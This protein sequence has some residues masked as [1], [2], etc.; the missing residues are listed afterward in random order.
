MEKGLSN[1]VGE[2][3]TLVDL[4]RWRAD[5]SPNRIAYR[6][7]T[8]GATQEL[9]LTYRELDYQARSIGTVLQ[10]LEASGE[11]VLLLYP[12]GLEYIAA[13]FGCLY[14][15]AV[16]V[17]AYPPR[18]NRSLPRL[19]AVVE[20]A[21]A[22]L[23]LTTSH[24]LSKLDNGSDRNNPLGS[25]RCIATD[26]GTRG[27]ESEWKVPHLTSETLAFLQ[28]TSGSTGTP[29]GVMVTH[30][31]LLHNSGALAYAFEYSPES[32]CVSWLPVYHDMGL[33]GG[34]LQPLYGGFPCALMSP[35]SFLQSP[36]RWLEAITRFKGTISGAP[37]FAYE[38]CVS[39][40]GP[41]QRAHL[42]L[43]SWEV[44]FNG[45]E[46]IR[47]ETLDRFAE[48]F[49]PCGFRKEAFFACYGLAES[50]L[51]VSGGERRIGPSIK[52]VASRKLGKNSAIE[53]SSARDDVRRV[54][55]CGKNL[56]GQKIAILDPE[57]GAACPP[58]QIGEVWVSSP[59][60]AK[61]YWNRPDETA[62]TFKARIAETG[63]GPFLR[64]GDLGFFQDGELYITGR[65]KD[66]I[67]IRGLNHYPQD[68]EL[69]AQRSH[70]V[71]RRGLAA[72]FS[73]EEAG[74]ERLVIIQE[75][76]PRVRDAGTVID[77]I[78]RAVAEDHDL[79]VEA[80]GLVRPGAISKT[81]SGKIR[82]H[83][84][85]EAF[86]T[87]QLK[88]LALW[89]ASS[90]E[91]SKPL[92]SPSSLETEEQIQRWLMSLVSSKL[93]VPER[94]MDVNAPI[95]SYGMDS[96]QA[97]ELTHRIESTLGVSLPMSR[98]LEGPSIA[99]IASL[100]LRDGPA[101]ITQTR[102]DL[103][104][105]REHGLYRLLHGQRALWFLHQLAPESAS[106]NIAGAARILTEIDVPLFREA[107]RALVDRHVSLRTT[108]IAQ[109][110]EP[111][112]QI[113]NNVE[114]DF[115]IHDASQWSES[116][117]S[118]RLTRHAHMPFDLERGPLM[119]VVVFTRSANEHIVLLAVHH[120]VADFWSLDVLLNELKHLYSSG[121]QG[122]IL[123][124]PRQDYDY[125]DYVDWQSEMLNGAEGERLWNYWSRQ[126]E[127]ELPVLNLPTDR[128]RPKSQTF[129]GASHTFGLGR[130]LTGQIEELASEQ[131]TTLFMTLLA[132]FQ[133]LLYRYTGQDDLLLGSLTSGRRSA[134][135]ADLCG[136]LVNPLVLRADLS[137]EPPF[138]DY[139]AR[140][141]RTV[142]D[143]FE[144]QDYPFTL[145]VERLQPERDAT[146]S[147]LFQVMFVLQKS[148][149]SDDDG[150]AA[151]ALSQTGVRMRLGDIPLESVA[152]RQQTAQFDI[153]L[154]MAEISGC[155]SASL[156][157]NTDLFDGSTIQRMAGHF[158][159]LLES[160]VAQ[161]REL[162]S[163]LELLT[164]D[165]RHQLIRGWNQTE[166]EAAGDI[167]IH[168][169]FEAQVNRDPHAQAVIFGD[170]QVSYGELND[171][172]DRLAR[173][174]R[175]L[176]VGP[177][178]AVCV[179]V[180][181]SVEMLVGML[182]ILKAGGMYVPLD[183]AYPQERL[184]FILNDVGAPLLLTQARLIGDFPALEAEIVY[185]D[186]HPEAVSN[187]EEGES[188]RRSHPD[189]L[190]Y[191]IYTS[192]STGKPKGVMISHRS[193]VNFFS[194]M[195]ER[196]GCDSS[197]TLLAVTSI[198]FDISVL[199]L[200]W[201]LAR[202]GRVVLLDE[203]AIGAGSRRR[204]SRRE[205]KRIDFSLFYFASNDSDYAGSGYRLLF[206]GAKFADAN[207]FEAVWTPERHFHEF[208]GL[209]PNP[210]VMSSAIAAMTERVKIR[211]GSVVLP[212]HHPLRI[213]EEWSLVDN[214]S[215]GRVGIAFASGWHANDFVFF[216][217]N[218]DDRKEL[219]FR[220]VDLIRRLWRGEAIKVHGGAG[221]EIE[222]KVFP[223][224][225]QPELP[226][227]ITAAGTPDTFIKAGELGAGV[228]TH[229]LGQTVEGVAENIRLYRESLAANGYNPEAGRVT[230]MLHTF[231]GED[232][233][234]VRAMVRKPFKNYLRSSVG[235]IANM[236]KSL[237]LP[238]D[239]NNISPEDMDG[240]LEYAFNRYFDTSALFGTPS[241]CAEM[242]E[243]LRE[244]G[245]D[246]VACLL[247]FGVE[248]ETVL[249]S[250]DYLNQL[251]ELVN[252]RQDEMAH[253]L[254]SQAEKYRPSLMQCTPSM[255][256]MIG[257]VPGSLESLKPL[258]ALM[259][260]GEALP[261]SLVEEVKEALP[262]RIINMYG[263]TETTIWS[264][265]HEVEEAGSVI[266][267]GQPIANTQIFILDRSGQIVPVG[268]AGE[269]YIGGEGLAY[270]YHN[271]PDLTA[272]RFIPNPFSD[273][274]GAR[275]YRTG[276]LARRL[277]NGDIEFLGRLDQQV[278]VR[279]F[280][281]ELEEIETV[282]S[283]HPGISE[284]VVVVREDV[285]GDKRLA[286]Y[287]VASNDPVTGVPELQEYIR[288]RLPDYM[289][290]SHF[291]TLDQ[292]PLTPNGKVDRKKLPAPEASRR[293]LKSK[294]MPPRDK[295]ESLIA[296]I[297]QQA[298]NIEKVGVQDNFFDLG[299]HSLLMAQV[300]SQLRDSL[301]NDLP[302]IKM[303]EH[304]TIS[305]LAEFINKGASEPLALRQAQDRANK[306]RQGLER[307]R[308]TALK[309]RYK[310]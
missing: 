70:P 10:S 167:C 47:A 29:K 247:D 42:D 106:Y 164:P 65:L 189:D 122:T 27:S 44:A 46:P 43:S 77:C 207:G 259:L 85:R 232:R 220:G 294:Y 252:R 83:A 240:L 152:V 214:I 222:V 288:Q 161:P 21:Q 112:Q 234:S 5:E 163:R 172:A 100:T 204:Y 271:R 276:D 216:P 291:I 169:L 236:I 115:E 82:R 73:V 58:D 290:P 266:P 141:R 256:R 89:R 17:P 150:L 111:L 165:E 213:A 219:T 95:D 32:Q 274:A 208:G 125:I 272:E 8:D 177:Q 302:L 14:A 310:I 116:F 113:H 34:V 153:V 40:I 228:L 166:S 298:L 186:S 50:T 84:C 211:A 295:L 268:I 137:G 67:I 257:A 124:L 49:E 265:T 119:R 60:V 7:L 223:R 296:G 277:P 59:S 69:S 306:L 197:D 200:F 226:V 87:G 57:S 97:I 99:Q 160:M 54:V 142:L 117:L 78:R 38:L 286:A 11:R 23:A 15:G 178:V 283:D 64:T 244:I 143:A 22:T 151:L 205:D 285:P 76:S 39:K 281:I 255:M 90:I 187:Q 20:D 16:A 275:L 182:A 136:Y 80:V 79:Q 194:A 53:A 159:T 107:F 12:P 110:G 36:F 62:A 133:V 72:A 192:G 127:G 233:E 193:V 135:F 206:E 287:S 225:I 120:I 105:A 63:Q 68:I 199:E 300:H 26:E 118:E 126:L 131:S 162:V 209:Y 179:I 148:H 171:R 103:R 297:W 98:L 123:M 45:S 237:N 202:G 246:E 190:A 71:L 96:L 241:G 262:A 180:E 308:R 196:I 134:A 218:Y 28:Y 248:V 121:K 18:N 185:L 4:L 201:T 48:A 144:H 129:C 170:R 19:M 3:S 307:Q 24:I 273:R 215:K 174:L 191:V 212:L 292:L 242:I 81:S 35:A 279:G 267:V 210:S 301:Q 251:K 278:K 229:L 183:P 264:A 239:I 284:T 243:H 269:L 304:P 75:V 224:P 51:I 217:Q 168:H 188:Y 52:S 154:V 139:L 254:P 270:G 130:E 235:L 13:F 128:P 33:I 221:N 37:N 146:R 41:E 31:N 250:L 282:L 88:S 93:G 175:S 155:L 101:P 145:L 104:P 181:R 92:A 156:Q 263:P 293:D 253:S 299:G 94:D 158:Q 305:S 157:Y 1:S 55:S 184:N 230:L 198:S 30:S 102:S 203:Q 9:W 245:I 303:L 260:G 138:V 280:R 231:V 109:N 140:V 66:L 6:F 238:F 249:A 108:F 227:W 309:A 195:D 289:V 114:L 261:P 91:E 61:G 56:P 86:L 132:A 149:L 74:E 173:H 2:A 176:G 258:R 147:P 25:L